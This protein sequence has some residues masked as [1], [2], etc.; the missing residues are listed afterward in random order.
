MGSGVEEDELLAVLVLGSPWSPVAI[1]LRAESSRDGA[2]RISHCFDLFCSQWQ[3][4]SSFLTTFTHDN[5]TVV[6]MSSVHLPT[7]GFIYIQ[8]SCQNERKNHS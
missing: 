7:N 2:P 1:I 3:F 8:T 6:E 5:D 4:L